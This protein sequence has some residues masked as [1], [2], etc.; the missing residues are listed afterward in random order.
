MPNQT[1]HDLLIT[2]QVDLRFLRTQVEALS[3]EVAKLTA[4][5]RIPR[6]VWNAIAATLLALAG[7][8]GASAYHATG[9]DGATP[10]PQTQRGP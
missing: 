8:I 7:W 10:A 5:P 9:A 3:V 1:D 2:M 6:Q 4:A